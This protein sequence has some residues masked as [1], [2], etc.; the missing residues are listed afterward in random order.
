MDQTVLSTEP[1]FSL[2]F[3]GDR[4][5]LP[6]LVGSWTRLV[7]GRVNHDGLC[8]TPQYFEHLSAIDGPGSLSLLTV[9]ADD[10]RLAGV[11][12]VHRLRWAL[13]FEI[14]GRLVGESR[15]RAAQVLGS[16]PLVPDDPEL[17]DR[18]FATIADEFPECDAVVMGSVPI[19]SFL[20][21]YGETSSALRTRFL[22]Y[23][24]GRR[25]CHTIPLPATY[26][27]YL[28]K[29]SGK[30][31]YNLRRQVRRLGEAV[32]LRCIERPD[33]VPA[34]ADAVA[35]LRHAPATGPGRP[36]AGE[37]LV[38]VEKFTDL[39]AHGLLLCYVL[40]SDGRP[41][42]VTMGMKHAATYRLL[43]IMHDHAV[44]ELS[45][46]STL[47]FMLI[48]DLIRRHHIETI[49]FGF[50]EP[51]RP[52][53][54]IHVLEDRASLLLFRKTLANRGRRTAH[55][56]FRAPVALMKRWLR[57]SPPPA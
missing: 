44:A 4:W 10:G 37:A 43:C 34:L 53:P 12:P 11:V 52:Y 35:A 27:E 19:N 5:Q 46:G 40:V 38:E 41:C 25:S 33:D 55:A 8:Q 57:T 21:R 22:V 7:G 36:I 31:R 51:A 54:S 32:E 17:H 50:G 24:Y 18:V 42:A 30:K 28:G 15:F 48:E 13:P 14:S 16:Q 6:E 23:P 1:G 49:D 29:L 45:P 9:Q 47:V 39:A 20:W 2:D 56:A 3:A 26:E